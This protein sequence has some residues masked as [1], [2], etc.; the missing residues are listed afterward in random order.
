MAAEGT[1]AVVGEVREVPRWVR[2]LVAARGVRLADKTLYWWSVHLSRFL[3][4]CRGAGATASENLPSAI[5]QY[6]GGMR[7]GGTSKPF[8]V[9]QARQA[10]EVFRDGV[11]NW[12][13]REDGERAGPTFRL[14]TRAGVGGSSVKIL[15][16]SES[17]S[18][19]ESE[20]SSNSE[21]APLPTLASSLPPS[22]LT[23]ASG[24]V[25]D[26]RQGVAGIL[27]TMCRA[28]RVRHYGIRTEEAYLQW[29]GRFLTYSGSQDPKGLAGPEVQRF[30]E[31]LALERNVSASTQNQAFS[32]LLFL[33]GTVLG[34][35]LERLAET[36]RAR[37]PQRLPVVLSRDEAQR[38]LVAMEG[39][40]GVMARIL[41]G[42]GLR[43]MEMLRLRV[44]D[45][46]FERGLITVREGK[47]AKDR[48]VMLPE[49]LRG[50]LLAH[51]ERAR[52]LFDSDREAGFAGVWLPRA[53]EVKYPN[54]G[55]E[56]GWQWVFPSK[57]LSVDPRSG[58]R[59]R[60]HVH[61]RTIGR[62]IGDARRTAGI[63]KPV[64]AHS[65]RHSFATH[66]LESGADIRTVQELLGHSS[67]E[68]TMIYTHVMERRGVAGVRSP[69][70]DWG[71]PGSRPGA[72]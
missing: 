37:R 2:R 51:L 40:L 27:E 69:L 45:I 70:D 50:P 48:V 22:G 9:E 7:E 1:A 4:Y 11:E 32:A 42:T 46:D 53:L 66:L 38:L 12:Q 39:T 8:Q 14:K 64:T 6:L 20:R 61:D 26:G 13:W 52:V 62:A 44:K 71:A 21:S 19:S 56:W 10:L 15:D 3:K 41:Y 60:H 58:L 63:Q 67:L 23:A 28:L 18:V 55:K 65:L 49:S 31:H 35:P 72:A 30:L 24:D 43:V 17:A 33:F 36:I 57:D 29:A 5:G 16:T 47:G 34:R 54:A 25:W 68:T 59:R